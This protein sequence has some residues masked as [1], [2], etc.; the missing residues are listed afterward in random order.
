MN[1][2]YVVLDTN[3]IVSAL[4]SKVGN[5][6]KILDRFLVGELIL[7]YNE[8]ILEEYEDVLYRPKLKI[9][10]GDVDTLITDILQNGVKVWPKPSCFQMSDEDDRCFYDT[11]KEVGSYL[12]TGN[13]KHYPSEAFILT[14][15]DFLELRR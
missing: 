6:A 11:A 9:P 8:E 15:K 1:K 2:P 4:L 7:I 14:P 13:I 3:V 5:P 10:Q 12:I